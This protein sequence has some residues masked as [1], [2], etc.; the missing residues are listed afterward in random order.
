M[1]RIDSNRP[2]Y[3]ALRQRWAHYLT[4]FV[5]LSLIIGGL[6]LRSQIQSAVTRYVDTRIG[7]EAAYPANWLIET[8]VDDV[9]FRVRNMALAGY[10]S[11]IQ[12]TVRPVSGETTER[13][14]GD[15]LALERSLVLTDY[16]V[17][18][19]EDFDLNGQ[20]AQ[21]I[22]YTYASQESSPFLQGIPI[23]VEGLDILLIQREQ[24]IVI[25]FR[26]Q[27]ESFESERHYFDRFLQNLEF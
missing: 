21:A 17:I 12:I 27:A 24:A 8:N 16:R 23:V 3:L 7:I 2:T 22:T 25:T 26:A 11:N 19:V 14:I 10:K 9:A 13:N 1:L 15:Q 4:V 5:A 18:S 6:A 20:R